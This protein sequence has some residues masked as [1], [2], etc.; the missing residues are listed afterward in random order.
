MAG[1]RWAQALESFDVVVIDCPASVGPLT[2]SALWAA[3]EILVPVRVEPDALERVPELIRMVRRVWETPG[4]RLDFTGV[5]MTQ[6]EVDRPLAGPMMDEI[7]EF[8][9]EIVLETV[10][11]EDEAAAEAPWRMRPV[12]ELAPRSR[13]AAAYVDLGMEGL[14]R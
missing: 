6:L 11:P 10:I 14:Q 9:G 2:E 1:T 12:L 3:N 4:P 8:F 13:V 7:R 5:L